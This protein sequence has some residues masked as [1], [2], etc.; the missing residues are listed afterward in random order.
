VSC[1][2]R[3]VD[4][5]EEVPMRSQVVTVALVLA[6]GAAAAQDIANQGPPPVL[7]VSRE[8]IKPGKLGPHEKTVA[9]YTQLLAKA[10]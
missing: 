4:V 2:A 3:A 9:L 8:E 6:A 1:A 7:G 10:T 5:Q